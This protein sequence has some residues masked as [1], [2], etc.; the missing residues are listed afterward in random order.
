MLAKNVDEIDS[1]LVAG[2]K[3]LNCR[4]ALL[5][6]KKTTAVM[7]PITLFTKKFAEGTL[8]DFKHIWK[9]NIFAQLL[10]L[11]S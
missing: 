9:E 1:W 8:C 10:R 3:V 4:Y 6:V 7:H 11:K 5:T 2:T